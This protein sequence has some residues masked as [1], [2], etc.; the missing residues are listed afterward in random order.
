MTA[1]AAPESRVFALAYARRSWRIAPI[2]QGSKHPRFNDWGSA[3]TTD[4]QLIEQWYATHRNDGVGI[5]TGRQSGLL[6]VDIDTANDKRGDESLLDLEAT[7]G[8]LPETAEVVTGS[9]GRHLYYRI[10]ADTPHIANSAGR[11]GPGIDI[12]CEGGQVVAPPSIHPETGARYEWEA[13]SHPDS[14][15]DAPEWLIELLTTVVDADMAPREARQRDTGALTPGDLFDAFAD[16]VKVIIGL[17]GGHY[18]GKRVD[19]QEK[20]PYHL[21]GRPAKPG[22]VEHEPHTSATWDYRGGGVLKVFTDGWRGVTA[23]GVVWT[24]DENQTYS[25]FGLLAAVCYEGS[26]STTAKALRAGLHAELLVDGWEDLAPEVTTVSEAPGEPVTTVDDHEPPVE[27][28][29]APGPAKVPVYWA[30][31]ETDPPGELDELVTNLIT[32]GEF[33]VMG[34]PRA[35]GKTWATMQLARI[36]AEGEGRMFGSPALEVTAPPQTV[37]YMQGEL[38]RPSSYARWRLATRGRPPHVA[39]VFERLQ[40]KVTT[41]RT[42]QVIDGVTVS[43]EVEHA[44][45]DHRLEPLLEELGVDLLVLDPWA[46]Y[47]AGNENNNDQTESAIDALTQMIRRTGTAGWIVHHI[48]AKAVHGNLA[49]PEDL[50]RGATRLADAVATRVTMLPHYTPAKVKELGM[51]RHEARRFAD[52]HILQ[53][54]GPPVPVVHT[55]LDAFQWVEWEAPTSEGG[56]PPE[57]SQKALVETLER[58]GGSVES[59]RKLAAATG[60]A[61]S[62]LDRVLLQC[63]QLGLVEEIAGTRGAVGYRLTGNENG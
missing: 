52:V 42:M 33:T 49:E 63:E 6:V 55:K 17:A 62:T 41:T 39:E 24:L 11:L 23:D 22:E 12:R 8:K 61:T 13:S 18:I 28:E 14:I 51:E 50:W 53:R 38:G 36:M 10:G 20:H 3:A 37:L 57:F 40:V 56:R 45:V 32:R 43:D 58:L 2:P 35:M 25:P 5:V 27:L 46:T 19:W 59:K 47:Y 16:P 29:S 31:D 15:V 21:I 9:G 26:H 1:Q 44:L 4:A 48:S 34:A 7:Y 60:K 30:D 54:L